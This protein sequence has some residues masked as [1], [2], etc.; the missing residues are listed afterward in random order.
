MF[1][2]LPDADRRVM[3]WFTEKLE[4]VEFRVPAAPFETSQ[5]PGG[6]EERP[7]KKFERFLKN[8]LKVGETPV[9]RF[10]CPNY[11][12]AIDLRHAVCVRYY[13]PQPFAGP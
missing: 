9:F 2:E 4:P 11:D 10:T 8:D 6:R 13:R 3:V 1:G 7:D 5:E 12:L